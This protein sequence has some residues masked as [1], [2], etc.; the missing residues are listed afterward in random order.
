MTPPGWPVSSL[1]KPTH[2]DDLYIHHSDFNWSNILA[3]WNN[4]DKVTL[5]WTQG[6]NTVSEISKVEAKSS[7]NG[8][9]VIETDNSYIIILGYNTDKLDSI[10]K[11]KLKIARFNQDNKKWQTINNPHIYPDGK[12]ATTTNKFGYFA[13]VYPRSWWGGW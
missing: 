11:E 6:F 9:P 7:F 10:P 4:P 8:Y 3:F 13:V 2:R 12:I 1:I 5:P